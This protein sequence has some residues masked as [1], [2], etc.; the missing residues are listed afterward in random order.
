MLKKR[1]SSVGQCWEGKENGRRRMG[2]VTR[3]MFLEVLHS[4]IESSFSGIIE[5]W[6]SETE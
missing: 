3:L 5:D 6:V 1:M 2:K 4:L